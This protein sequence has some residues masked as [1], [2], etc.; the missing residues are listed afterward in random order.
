MHILLFHGG[1]ISQQ[2]GHVIL[3]NIN[4]SSVQM[5]RG[6]KAL[7]DLG[8]EEIYLRKLE[9]ISVR[10]KKDIRSRKNVWEKTLSEQ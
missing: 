8:D 1:L 4:E 6:R 5:E 7:K 2:W 3:L 10:G 9:M